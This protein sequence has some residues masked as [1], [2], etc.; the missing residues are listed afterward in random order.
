MAKTSDLGFTNK[1]ASTSLVTPVDIKVVTNYAKIEDEPQVCVL[2]NRT[3]PL[4]Q[5]ELVTYRSNELDKVSSSQ[6]IQNPTPVRNGVQYV[7]KV[8]DI[9]RTTD[10]VTGQIVDEPVVAYLTIR[11]QKTGNITPAIVADVVSRCVGACRRS[12]GTW[13]FDDLMRSAVAPIVD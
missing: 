4:D 1:T 5:G 2:S 6:V 12:N 7:I 8:E 13:R 3:S 10:S 9:L 11:H